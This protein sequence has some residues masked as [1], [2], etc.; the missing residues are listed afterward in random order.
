MRKAIF[1]VML[2]GASFAGGAVVNGPG[3]QWA[4]TMILSHL[5]GDDEDSDET[6]EKSADTAVAHKST[7]GQEPL[8]PIPSDPITP[9]TRAVVPDPDPSESLTT[10]SEIAPRREPPTTTAKA[11]A[12]ASEPR[13]QP[14]A[15]TPPKSD[16]TAQ[17]GAGA[18]DVSTEPAALKS[19]NDP[20]IALTNVPTPLP[21]SAP[22]SMEPLDPLPPLLNAP[23][24][25]PMPSATGEAGK[26]QDSGAVNN[27]LAAAPA[28]I[29]AA[30]SA[31]ATALDQ[32]PA[33]KNGA[34]LAVA[35]PQPPSDWAEIRRRMAAL[36][37][38]RY[39]IEGEPNGKVRFHCVIPLAGRRAVAQ[40]F[41]AEGNDEFQ[42]AEV[43]LR[44]VALWRAT[45]N[46]GP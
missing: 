15:P 14:P 3:L 41:E 19:P 18:A 26:G 31:A 8:A 23:S 44:R 28:A 27:A 29:A 20:E 6:D 37:V 32:D 33:K 13:P 24:A 12:D 34:P 39:G 1:A 43:A 4:Q 35:A 17:L 40:Q 25:S 9:A 38:S 21:E 42:A 10:H 30:A 45:E 11:L 5:N 16:Q 22:T 36:G 7:P 46:P 2:I